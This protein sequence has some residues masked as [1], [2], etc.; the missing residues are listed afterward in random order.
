MKGSKGKPPF[1]LRLPEGC[2]PW[3][4][5]S[6]TPFCH[7]EDDSPDCPSFAGEGESPET[8]LC[9]LM[10]CDPWQHCQPAVEALVEA[11]RS[12]GGAPEAG[13][14]KAPGNLVALPAP[15]AEVDPGVVEILEVVLA[16][17]KR[18]EVTSAAIACTLTG[19]E[20]STSLRLPG[21][22]SVFALLGTIEVLKRRV[23][24]TVEEGG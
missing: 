11:A 18:G 19:G 24:R 3:W 7:T 8:G 13:V 22:G 21:G 23:L 1:E 5:A 4:D 15:A 12:R 14:E 17:A 6:G 10:G 2:Q 9:A 16:M 20:V